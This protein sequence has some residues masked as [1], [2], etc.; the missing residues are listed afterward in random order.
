MVSKERTAE[1]VKE[2]GKDEHDTGDTAVQ[3]ALIT[4]SIKLLTAH[5][6]EHKHDFTAK[7]ALN[8]DVAKRARLLSYLERTDEKRFQEVKAKLGLR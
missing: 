6:L 8:I 5:L 1:L 3:I 7:R 4:E 2:F